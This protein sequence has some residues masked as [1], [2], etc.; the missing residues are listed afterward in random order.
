MVFPRVRGRKVGKRIFLEGETNCVL[1]GHMGGEKELFLRQKSHTGSAGTAG[2]Q[3][4]VEMALP[5]A[6]E[7]NPGKRFFF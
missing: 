3:C 4:G 1:D 7:R 5:P 6:R 2:L